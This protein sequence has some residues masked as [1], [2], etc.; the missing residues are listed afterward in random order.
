MM[1]RGREGI[2]ERTVGLLRKSGLEMPINLKDFLDLA[3]A[4]DHRPYVREVKFLAAKYARETGTRDFYDIY[5]RALLQEAPYNLDSYLLFL[6]FNRDPEKKFYQ[7]RRHVLRTLVGDLQQLED[8]ELDFLSISTPP[9]IGKLLADETPVL[10]FRGWKTHGELV[11]GDLVLGSNWE[12]VPV[13][14][15]HPKHYTTHKVFFS[16]G[17]EV[18]AHA[19]HE[20]PVRRGRWGAGLKETHTLRPGETI[21]VGGWMPGTQLPLDDDPY[22]VGRKFGRDPL[23]LTGDGPKGRIDYKY[24]IAPPEPRLHLLAGLLDPD[25]ISKGRYYTFKTHRDDIY[26]DMQTL[27][28]TFGTYPIMRQAPPIEGTPFGI[29]AKQLLEHRFTMDA[30]VPLRELQQVKTI[31]VPGKR[32]KI[33]GVEEAEPRPGH[34]IT[35]EGG[36]YRIGRSLIP[37]HN[38]T[39]GC[40]FITWVMGRHPDKAN[41]MSGYSDLLTGKFYQE[42]L[43]VITEDRYNWGQ[44]FP[45]V[46][47]HNTSASEQSI[48]LNQYQRFPALTCRSIEGSLTGAVEVG[49][50]LYCDDLIREL[51]EALNY[52]RLDKK[53]DA[54][55]NQLKDRMKDGAYQLMIGTRWS[56]RDVQGR[57]EDQYRDNPRY[58]FRVIP[59][60][61]E[62][63]ETNFD[64]DHGHG[65]STAYYMDMKDSIDDA[66]W[67]AKYMGDPYIREGLLFPAD[68]LNYYNGLLP[69]GEPDRIVAVCDVAWGGGDS[70]SMPFFYIYDEKIFVHDVIFNNGDKETTR[71]LVIAKMRLHR[72]HMARWESDGGG[73]EYAHIVD[74]KLRAQGIKLN[75]THAKA[76]STKS[77]LSRIIQVSPEIK[78]F[79]YRDYKNSSEEYRNFMKELTSFVITGKNKHDDAPDSLA[80]GVNFINYGMTGVEIFQRPY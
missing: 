41:L 75:I 55:A 58:R 33:T 50:C 34:C 12:W 45:H 46:S 5:A 59:A 28:S 20:W 36:I 21:P 30:H 63:G 49:R 11:V 26:E 67:T 16:D 44:I 38:S 70:L 4:A 39:L 78:K 64:Y 68:E 43:S 53:Y 80:M 24:L 47:I 61:D 52:D 32:L 71:P 6:E 60:L 40:F 3:R 72:P 77:K 51:E 65:F 7:P 74:E 13:L 1:G 69:D 79:Y 73:H 29:G 8:R 35:V 48:Q 15:I 57:I 2:D 25:G 22:E 17:S 18:H 56:V 37:T 23:G 66:T 14:A 62:K 76:P 19:N 9:R 54:Y 10:T 27:L 42:V 31:S